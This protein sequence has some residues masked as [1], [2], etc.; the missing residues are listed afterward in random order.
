MLFVCRFHMNKKNSNLFIS[1]NV[2]VCSFKGSRDQGLNSRRTRF[3]CFICLLFLILQYLLLEFYGKNEKKNKRILLNIMHAILLFFKLVQNYLFYIFFFF[4][5]YCLC[6][7]E[8]FHLMH[9]SLFSFIH[10]FQY[11]FKTILHTKIVGPVQ[12]VIHQ[13]AI[14][15]LIMDRDSHRKGNCV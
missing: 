14:V 7:Y 3:A 9:F 2:Y 4:I 15:F 12:L 6:F 11:S 5:L 8:Y 1:K 10:A 13:I